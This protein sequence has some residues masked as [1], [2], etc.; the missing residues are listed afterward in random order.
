MDL[1]QE[2]I[3]V[4]RGHECGALGIGPPPPPLSL[5]VPF[6]LLSLPLRTWHVYNRLQARKRTLTKNQ[7]SQHPDHGLSNLQNWKKIALYFLSYRVMVCH[8]SSPK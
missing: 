8:H 7:L 5:S 6:L 2:E 3:M 4:R 1:L